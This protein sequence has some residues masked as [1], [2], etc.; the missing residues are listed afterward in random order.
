M[1][2]RW[3]TML[4]LTAA[5]TLSAADA[6]PLQ[7]SRNGSWK[8]DESG[9]Q[10]T[11]TVKDGVAEWS[12]VLAKAELEAK[13]YYRF[14]WRMTSSKEGSSDPLVL[15]VNGPEKVRLS[16][17]TTFA[18]SPDIQQ[19]HLYTDTC[20]G[21]YTFSLRSG[22][23]TAQTLTCGELKLEKLSS[24]DLEQELFSSPATEFFH[25]LKSGWRNAVEAADDSSP[26]GKSISF[27]LPEIS[28]LRSAYLPVV[29]GKTYRLELW[30]KG[31]DVLGAK[32]RMD[33]YM[34]P[35]E[36]K[37]CYRDVNV[38]VS[39]SWKKVTAEWKVPTD[40]AASPMLRSGMLRLDMRF[41]S[42]AATVSVAGVSLKMVKE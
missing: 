14:S 31:S 20:P 33:T 3:M 2:H 34:G 10:F 39:K 17:Y 21:T 4:L 23:K 32:I 38:S 25:P 6:I 29:P 12:Q 13:S 36:G 5:G 7:L 37:H 19:F 26:T 28:S 16:R 1:K 30:V 41:N 27:T 24:S 40:T 22:M 11:R 8:A 15:E 18:P 9:K 42:P 35:L